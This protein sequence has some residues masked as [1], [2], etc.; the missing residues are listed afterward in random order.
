M[1]FP[2]PMPD[3]PGPLWNKHGRY[4]PIGMWISPPAMDDMLLHWIRL[5]RAQVI[6]GCQDGP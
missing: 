6:L 4:F 3:M 2:S 5:A 1:I